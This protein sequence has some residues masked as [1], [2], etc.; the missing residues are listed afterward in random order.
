MTKQNIRLNAICNLICKRTIADIGS[1][2]GYVPKML[3]SERKIDH[4][5]VTDISEKCVA[6]AKNNLK[7]F[8]DR[9]TFVVCNGLLGLKNVSPLP[10]QIVIAGM[11]GMEICKILMQDTLEQ[12]HNFVLQPQKNTNELRVFLQEN[13]FEIEKDFIIRDGKMFYNIIVAHRTS[14]RSALS[15]QQIEFGKTNLTAPSA[16]FL[17]YLNYKIAK[18]NEILQ[19]TTDCNVQSAL[20]DYLSC[21][22]ELFGKLNVDQKT[23]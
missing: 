14:S 15:P 6:K 17:E 8:A 4:A 12:F 23:K 9:T 16:D 21:R 22:K 10:Q 13:C 18:F 3:L 2:H 19:K 1:D 20:N 11:G 7:D 5:Y